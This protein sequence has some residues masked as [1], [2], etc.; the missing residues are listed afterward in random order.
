MTDKS[1]LF[2]T[3]DLVTKHLPFKWETSMPLSWTPRTNCCL[4]EKFPSIKG[5]PFHLFL[6]KALPLLFKGQH[7]YFPMCISW[8]R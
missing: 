5:K 4:I 7:E 2:T 8:L 6:H 3:R 1:Q